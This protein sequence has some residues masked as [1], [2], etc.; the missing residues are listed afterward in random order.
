MTDTDLPPVASLPTP[1]PPADDTGGVTV[2]SHSHR[3]VLNFCGAQGQRGA[4]DLSPMGPNSHT[5]VDC[6][7]GW[8][9]TPRQ[10]QDT[11]GPHRDALEDHKTEYR[12]HVLACL[13]S[14]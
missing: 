3:F 13:V 1:R 8:K 5:I 14:G 9:G 6:T 12:E 10:P 4:E 11:S 2:H 7:C